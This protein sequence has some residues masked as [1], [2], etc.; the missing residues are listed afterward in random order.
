LGA[1]PLRGDR[2][3]R[4]NLLAKAKRISASIP[5]AEDLEELTPCMALCMGRPVN[6]A[7]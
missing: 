1:S 4:S 7:G 3:I 5:C 6:A 2:A